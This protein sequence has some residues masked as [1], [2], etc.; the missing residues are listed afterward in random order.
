VLN[1]NFLRLKQLH[2]DNRNHIWSYYVRNV[3]RPAWLSRPENRV[4]V[5]VGNP[6]WLSYRHMTKEMQREFKALS[7]AR[8]FWHRVSTA[9]HQDLAG[10]FVARAVERYL[11]SGGRLAFVV[12]NSV[13]DRDYWSGFRRGVFDGAGVRFATSWDLRRVRPHMF[14]RGSAV[15][16]GERAEGAREMPPRAVV[17]RGKVP[18]RGAASDH[19]TGLAQ[20]LEDLRIGSD[21]DELSPYHA[22][23]ANGAN[24]FPRLMFRVEEA[25]GSALGVPAGQFSVKSR[26]TVAE[27]Q[28]WKGLPDLRGT[29][30]SQFVYPVYLGE[31]IV[32]F[33]VRAPDLNIVPITGNGGVLSTN[34][35]KIGA[36]PG[37]SSWMRAAED[38]WVEHGS[39]SMNLAEQIDHMG[40]L[41]QQVPLPTLR[42]VYAASGMHLSAALVTDNRA[43]VEHS[44]YWA[45]VS[46]E[47]EGHYLVG[48]LNTPTLT[49]LVRPFMAYGK[50]E[51][52]IDKAVWKL[53]IPAYD[54]TNSLH[55]EI[56]AVTE[57]LTADLAERQWRSDNFVT[58]RKDVRAWMLANQN[59]RK[60]DNL[61]RELL[62]EPPLDDA[63][64]DAPQ[65]RPVAA[66]LIR[67]TSSPLGIEPAD[68]EI[69]L[70]LEFDESRQ[71]YLWG[72]LVSGAGSEDSTYCAVGAPMSRRTPRPWLANSVS[73]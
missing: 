20:A 24:L 32:Q 2:E 49:E 46:S 11:K 30:E 55:T 7:R 21:E 27:N 57:A 56:V 67:L 69:D 72:Y 45:A 4:D 36:Y 61:V 10:L 63:E 14:P 34:G 54:N 12:P 25:G 62:G 1:E 50:D 59:G 44:A 15:I 22:R 38:L 23:F 31:H 48:I 47:S 35:D 9:T 71:V 39:S 18:R 28:P 33:K 73:N 58:I 19:V 65:V 70:D 16:F 60:L 29:V 3:S 68:I 41:T 42:V 43:F 40:K 6:P 53:P 66:G 5:L 17:W 64:R 13:I 51:R 52:H 37:L 8:E 26:R